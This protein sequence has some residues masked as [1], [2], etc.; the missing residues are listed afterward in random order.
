MNPDLVALYN[1]P[2]LPLELQSL[3]CLY[4]GHIRYGNNSLV[5]WVYF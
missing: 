5:Y 4:S 1:L 2:D 3:I